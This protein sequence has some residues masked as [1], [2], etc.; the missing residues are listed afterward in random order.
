MLAFGLLAASPWSF[1]ACATRGARDRAGASAAR[2][3]RACVLTMARNSGETEKY[4]VVDLDHMALTCWDIPAGIRFY[5]DVLKLEPVRLAEFER[6]EAPFVSLRLNSRCI[7]DLFPKDEAAKS[8]MSA[9]RDDNK[10]LG[11]SHFCLTLS[12]PNFNTAVERL[13]AAGT[14]FDVEEPIRRFGARGIGMSIY[15]R[16]PD[17]N[18]VELRYYPNDK[19]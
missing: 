3:G 18:Q 7:I 14:P 2:S 4:M 19:D 5:G 12:K 8:G 16:D 17:G 9:A 11:M 1:R 13:K 6:G 10:E 15:V